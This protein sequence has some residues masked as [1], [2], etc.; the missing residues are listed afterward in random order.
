VLLHSGGKK[1]LKPDE[2]ITEFKKDLKNTFIW[3][4]A[5]TILIFILIYYGI[6]SFPTEFL[7]KL[8]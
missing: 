3:S 5:Y 2:E 8:N 1:L 7:E 6:L 4:T